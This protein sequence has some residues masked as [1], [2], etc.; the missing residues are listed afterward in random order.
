MQAKKSN[1]RFLFPVKAMDIVYRAKFLQSLRTMIV[2]G[3]VILPD[4]TDTNE[5][6]NVLYSKDWVV[7]AKAPF[8]GPHGVIEYLGRYTHKVAI[9]NNRITDINEQEN[10]VTFGYKDYADA[11]KQKQMILKSGG[12][13]PALYSAYPAQ[14]VYKD[15]LLWL[16]LQPK[17]AS[18]VL[19]RY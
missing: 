4:S 8:G 12:V 19:N 1:Y 9:S 14:T 2:A 10:T 18:S 13:Y 3:E 16:P 17:Q 5:L 6:L 11:G 15:P 7:Y